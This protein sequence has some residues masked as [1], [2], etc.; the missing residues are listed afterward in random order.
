[1]SFG[2]WLIVFVCG[3]IYIH[4][5]LCDNKLWLFVEIFFRNY[6]LCRAIIFFCDYL[7]RLQFKNQKFRFKV[8]QR[9]GLNSGIKTY[10]LKYMFRIMNKLKY[11]TVMKLS[12]SLEEKSFNK[13]TV[14]TIFKF[15]YNSIQFYIIY[16]PSQQLQGQLQT[17]H[18]ADIHNYIMDR[19]NIE[20]R[21]NCRST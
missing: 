19:P 13:T 5:R 7:L 11:W 10:I 8:F 16:M 15:K 20:W 4:S 12:L 3:F 1:M 17:E 21:I 6:I 9:R 14:G 2:W 18:S